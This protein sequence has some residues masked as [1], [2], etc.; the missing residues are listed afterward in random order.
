MICAHCRQAAL[1][2][3]AGDESEAILLH[4]GCKGGTWCDCQHV[5]KAG[6]AAA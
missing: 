3:A 6:Q 5:L 2:L 4:A 1:E